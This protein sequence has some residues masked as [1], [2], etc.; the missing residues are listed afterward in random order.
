MTLL[1]FNAL[2]ITAVFLLSNDAYSHP[3]GQD[4]Y[5]CHNES[6]TGTYHCHSGPLEGQSFASKD[7]MLAAVGDIWTPTDPEDP[8]VPS[9]PTDTGNLDDVP[10]Y[11]RDLYRHWVDA[12]G[13]C[14]N[15]RHEV[16]IIESRIPVTLS[17][18]GCT[19]IAGEWYDPF[20]GNTYTNPSDLDIDHMVPL[21]E[22][23]YSGG[24]AWDEEKKKAYANDLLLS[25][26]LIAV[27]SSANRSKGAQDPASWLPPNADYHC[28]YV[29]NW[30]EIKRRHPMG[31]D[32]DE[33]EAI[34]SVL[35]APL[36]LGMREESQGWDEMAGRDSSAVF[37]LG[38]RR[39][40]Q[41][42]YTRSPLSTDNIEIT[43]SVLPDAE[44]I[45]QE[46]LV[47]LVAEMGGILYSLDALGQFTPWGGDLGTLIPFSDSRL[48]RES[49]EFPV[50]AGVLN[51]VIGLNLYI[52]YGTES[53]DFVYTGNPIPFVV[54][55]ESITP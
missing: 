55:T 23:H 44:H 32:R 31:L 8:P 39:V 27:S 35:G 50:F 19:V 43:V 54:A 42:A 14:Q 25:K 11:D 13:D 4:S 48:V 29:K 34:E 47:F 5:G 15:A 6:A 12:D 17:A 24:Y 20:T 49:F 38:V 33:W 30:L 21:A 7:A 2:A 1:R 45:N 36:E 28:E 10:P 3:G 9:D 52:G 46:F 16:L 40:D 53:G 51:E 37:G 18:N 22:T 26:S 41:C